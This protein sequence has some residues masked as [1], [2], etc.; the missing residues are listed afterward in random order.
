M[1]AVKEKYDSWEYIL[2]GLIFISI[3]ICLI[4]PLV[5]SSNTFF[6]FIVG[7]SVLSRISIE[8][9]F[10][11][12]LILA[13]R[14]PKYRPKNSIIIYAFIIWILISLMTGL[15]GVSIQRSLWSSFERMQGIIDLLHWFIFILITIINFC[16]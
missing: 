11:F 3:I 14:I 16:Y 4:T 6:P 7:K 9:A 13:Y 12:W 15:T 1:I 10:A 8:F 2:L 5:I